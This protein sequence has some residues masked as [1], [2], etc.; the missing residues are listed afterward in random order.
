MQS[1]SANRKRDLS[2]KVKEQ[3]LARKTVQRLSAQYFKLPCLALCGTV[4][5][6]L[7]RELREL[8]YK[9]IIGPEAVVPI[10]Q[11]ILESGEAVLTPDECLLEH[12]HVLDRE[13]VGKDFLAELTETCYRISAFRFTDYS[14]IKRFFDENRRICGLEPTQIVSKVHVPIGRPALDSYGDNYEIDEICQALRELARLKSGATIR[15]RLETRPWRDVWP[16]VHRP[17]PHRPVIN[18]FPVLV[19]LQELGYKIEASLDKDDCYVITT[20]NTDFSVQGWIQRIDTWS[21]PQFP[22]G[23]EG[24]VVARAWD[25]TAYR[26]R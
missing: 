12:K 2:D 9:G 21:G 4:S 24:R 23:L 20:E 26:I 17:I 6:K 25:L 18:I 10:S 3:E 13:A 15:V 14:H 5:T 1:E 22:G 7:P 8:V 16:P 19:E 11:T